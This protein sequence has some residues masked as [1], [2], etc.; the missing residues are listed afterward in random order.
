MNWTPR[1][2]ALAAAVAGV[3]ASPAWAQPRE[4]AASPPSGA[5]RVEPNHTEILFGVNHLGLTMYYGV[6]SGAHGQLVLD[7][8]DP[9]KSKLEVEVPVA[10]VLTPSPKLNEE[11]KSPAWL[12]AAAFPEMTY[13]ATSVTLTGPRTA[14]I[15]GELTLHGVT[16]P[17]SLEAKFNRGGENPMTHA[18]TIG[19]Q[20]HG[21]VKRSEFGVNTYLGPISDEV[22]VTV[23]AA[24][25]RAANS[26]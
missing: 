16:R 19:F 13:H 5:Y 24:F 26:Q 4:E 15:D 1:A 8:A 2:A 23:S 3:I 21:T 25:E 12:N 17:L 7:S 14:R 10:S 6:F 11:L 20:G 22:T 9:T 18:F